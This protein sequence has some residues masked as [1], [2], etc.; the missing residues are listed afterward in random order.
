MARKPVKC[1]KHFY[2]H[3]LVPKK[4]YEIYG[5]RAI[6]F[7]TPWQLKLSDALRETFGPTTINNY[8]WGGKRKDSGTRIQG[9]SRTGSATSAHRMGI[10]LDCVFRDVSIKDVWRNIKTY[11]DFWFNMGITRIEKFKGMDWLHIDGII[12]NKEKIHWFKP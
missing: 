4:A 7:I 9:W 12:T 1:N 2:V 10:A 3:E 6:R 11:D 8:Y 5:D